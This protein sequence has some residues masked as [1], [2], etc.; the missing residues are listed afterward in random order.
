M[1]KSNQFGEREILKNFRNKLKSDPERLI[2]FSEAAFNLMK[3]YPKQNI[4]VKLI[5][6]VMND[7]IEG[8]T[9]SSECQTIE[10]FLRGFKPISHKGLFAVLKKKFGRNEGSLFELNDCQIVLDY[11]TL[12]NDR[13]GLP[14]KFP[15][16]KMILTSTIDHLKF[17]ISGESACLFYLFYFKTII[18]SFLKQLPEEVEN[19]Y[20]SPKKPGQKENIKSRKLDI[21]KSTSSGNSS[22]LE[23]SP[24]PIFHSDRKPRKSKSKSSAPTQSPEPQSLPSPTKGLSTQS[25]RASPTRLST[26]SPRAS[27]K[28]QSTPYQSARASSRERPLT[29][30]AFSR[31]IPSPVSRLSTPSPTEKT[32]LPPT[33]E[34]VKENEQQIMPECVDCALCRV[35][36]NIEQ[37]I[38]KNISLNFQCS[39]ECLKSGDVLQQFVN[40][41]CELM[42]KTDRLDFDSLPAFREN[43]NRI[44]KIVIQKMTVGAP[45]FYCRMWQYSSSLKGEDRDRLAVG[46]RE[47]LEFCL[48]EGFGPAL[49]KDKEARRNIFEYLESTSSYFSFQ[50]IIESF[51]EMSRRGV[52]LTTILPANM[53]HI[54]DMFKDTIDAGDE[55]AYHDFIGEISRNIIS[56][57]FQSDLIEYF[58]ISR[59]SYKLGDKEME[60]LSDNFVYVDK[61]HRKVIHFLFINGS[62]FSE[63][64]A[65]N[66]LVFNKDLKIISSNKWNF[67]MENETFFANIK[68]EKTA[69][70]KTKDKLLENISENSF[71]LQRSDDNDDSIE[72]DNAAVQVAMTRITIPMKN[73]M[74]YWDS[75]PKVRRKFLAGMCGADWPLMYGSPCVVVMGYNYVKLPGSQKRSSNFAKMKGSCKVCKA[76][77]IFEV[78]ENP[79]NEEIMEDNNIEYIPVKDLFID[80]TVTGRFH[81]KVEGYPEEPDITRPIHKLKNATGLHLKGKE[82]ELI[83]DRAGKIGVKATYLEQLDYANQGHIEQGNITSVRSVPVIKMARREREKAQQGG[84]TFYESVLNV[85]ETQH[86]L[87]STNFVE[88]KTSKQFPGYIRY[89]SQIKTMAICFFLK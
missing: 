43:M 39:L 26:P 4:G 82:R 20:K 60:V 1:M 37:I 3:E 9:C 84:R 22:E 40:N 81:A 78:N 29:S 5:D 11:L 65:F 86:T 32:S 24:S 36:L 67:Y 50:S 80:V 30:S 85:Y 69:R 77:H 49:S 48:S 74:K 59:K 8:A 38:E 2:Q 12:P 47:V 55:L 51:Y 34:E 71:E 53:I 54:I 21:S 19:C 63:P 61:V 66:N 45:G 18:Q 6:E 23:K 46:T 15:P 58:E 33:Q 89:V 13:S 73:I 83:A 62:V 42:S 28:R 68:K 70:E 79:F 88:T 17:D 14:H 64:I 16:L 75:R 41:L 76:S 7:I 52:N 72:A 56:K 57:V 87:L 27:I 31:P 35:T 44:I 10:L 25:P